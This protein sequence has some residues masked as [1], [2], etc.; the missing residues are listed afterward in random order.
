[1]D[2]FFFFLR[3]FSFRHFPPFPMLSPSPLPDDDSTN[4]DVL[5]DLCKENQ[6]EQVLNLLPLLGNMNF[7]KKI[8][9]STGSTCLHVACYYGHRDMVKILLDCGAQYSIRNIPY[10]LTPYE[11]TTS[12]EIKQLLVG[13]QKSFATNDSNYIEWS[14]TGEGLLKKRR[15]F[16]HAI[17][18]YKN[19][20]NQ[21][22]VS[23]ILIEVIHY[24]LNE[25]LINQ[26]QLA[27]NGKNENIL[28]QIENIEGYFKEAIEKQDYLTYFIK[29]YTSTHF[30]YKVLN[31]DLALYVLEYF[32]QTTIFRPS[33]YRLV[34]CLVHIVTLL[35][36]HPNLPQYQFQGTC[37]RGMMIT[38]NDLNQY[39]LN[40]HI[41][42][43]AFLS[44]SV[45]HRVAK[46]FA[47][48]DQQ[49]QMRHTPSQ[50]DHSPIQYSCLCRYLIKQ[51]LTAINIQSLSAT[52]GEQEVLINPF[53]VFQVIDVKE[54][55]LE[56]PNAP[57]SIEIELEECEDIDEKND[58]QP[59]ESM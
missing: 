8:Q 3:R 11:E 24:Y 4:V 56:D 55:Y 18:L 38:Q 28:K 37:Y 1:M 45:D 35:M 26:S 27:D 42:N 25:H 36:H 32:D 13:R 22:L 46:M 12:D 6:I 58:R 33:N 57:I 49:S 29:A 53:S 14:I 59:L 10:N 39:K 43:R 30:F 21:H 34:N 17:D 44:T 23:R 2:V 16:C 50:Q 15:E 47:G 54:N 51:D 52:G 9:K 40:Q 41:M 20:D 48:I 19:Y 5:Y 31:R 7:I